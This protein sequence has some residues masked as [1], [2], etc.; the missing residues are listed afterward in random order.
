MYSWHETVF[1]RYNEGLVDIM[2]S[3]VEMLGEP[4][5]VFQEANNSSHN[6]TKYASSLN[7]D[8]DRDTSGFCLF[9][10]K[11]TQVPILNAVQNGLAHAVFKNV[12]VKQVYLTVGKP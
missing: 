12:G 11:D 1:F 8:G 10:S 3:S 7:Q 6:P 5:V 2:A 9:N 4:K